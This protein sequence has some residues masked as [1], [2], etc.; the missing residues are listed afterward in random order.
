MRK[1]SHCFNG[2]A[3]LLLVAA[4]ALSFC[5]HAQDSLT[6][7]EKIAMAKR[8]ADEAAEGKAESGRVVNGT[9]NFAEEL[10]KYRASLGGARSEDSAGELSEISKDDSDKH[11]E[12]VSVTRVTA[13]ET[14][15][16][17][18]AN[19][20][21]GESA[22][23]AEPAR[24]DA[25][26]VRVVPIQEE[27]DKGEGSPAAS[28]GI[29]ME[30]PPQIDSK[31]V[32]PEYKV[33]MSA[34]SG[35]YYVGHID[36][37]KKMTELVDRKL[38]ESK[39]FSNAVTGMFFIDSDS[40]YTLSEVK[41]YADACQKLAERTFGAAYSSLSDSDKIVL[42]VYASPFSGLKH[43]Y[44]YVRS[45]DGVV[46]ISLNLSGLSDA[47]LVCS[48]LSTAVL[49]K[50]ADLLGVRGAPPY[51]LET[52]FAQMLRQN[53]GEGI[54]AEM[55]RISSEWQPENLGAILEYTRYS[56]Q[57]QS[58]KESHCYWLAVCAEKMLRGKD[59]Y[60]AFMLSSISGGAKASEDLLR[61]EAKRA[62]V[63]FDIWFR[64]VFAGEVWSRLGGVNSPQRTDMEVA[65]LSV[66]QVGD[67]KGERIPLA[68]SSLWVN[69]ENV[70]SEIKSRITE[71]KVALA[72]ANPLYHNCLVTLGKM[73]EACLD[74]DE[75]S[76]SECRAMFLNEYGDAKKLSSEV[77]KMM[78]E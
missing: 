10:S 73:Y 28:F 53:M 23:T 7:A 64:T 35:G 5:A 68:D 8:M 59:A 38:K 24:T 47:K 30:R 57:A 4:N 77:K 72:R 1:I 74:N 27:D 78:S 48:M 67:S 76:F 17:K 46:T 52:A 45:S 26:P 50:I 39:K 43:D 33:D 18:S 41:N 15:S 58:V 36:D 32:K 29:P 14:A 25:E 31:P 42:Q 60:C 12:D 37:A 20:P 44:S 9:F 65:R 54:P 13:A 63:D 6:L 3:A 66:L 21:A 70:Q 34:F 71:I 2:I 51:W 61:G 75:K 19:S 11:S 62:N 69:R 55:G 56:R 49:R 16:E 40:A 22:S